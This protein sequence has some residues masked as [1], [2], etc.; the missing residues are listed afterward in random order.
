M[1][2]MSIFHRNALKVLVLLLM[3]SAASA[4]TAWHDRSIAEL[5]ELLIA[6]ELSAVTL[7]R[8]YLDR[9]EAFDTE[10]ASVIATSP[11][12][13]EQ[14]GAL[15]R[16]LAEGGTPGPLHGIPILLKDNIEAR[17]LPTTAGSL[18]LQ[19]NH[20]RRDA[21]LVASLR[22]AGAVI[23]GKTNLSE[24]ANFR[25]ERSSS[26]WSAVGGQ[27]RNP[28]DPTRT[29]C[30]SS[31]GSGVAV[32]AGFAPVAIGTE[33]NGSVV[34][35][36][37]ANGNAAI[38][39]TV[40]LVSRTHIVPISHTQD[41]AGPM[42]MNLADAVRVLAAMMGPDPADSA[43]AEQPDWDR[44]ELL[45]ALDQASLQGMR[46][47]VIRGLS[48]FHPRVTD[49]YEEAVTLLEASGA[50]VVDDL[51]LDWPDGFW[52]DTYSVLLHEFRHTLNSYLA[53]L[54][55]EQLSQLDLAALIEF[56]QTYAEVQMPWFGQEHFER[57][58]ATDGIESETYLEALARIQSATRAGG[59]DR[60][61]AEFEVDVLVSP[62]GGPAWKIDWIN[63]DHFG[64]GSATPA[65]VSGYPAITVPMGA[66]HGMPVGLSFFAGRY[67]E[68][69]LIRA[70]Q[71][72]ESAREP[73]PSPNLDSRPGP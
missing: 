26:G 37:T 10:L 61:L 12:A 38:K 59:I 45:D 40:G 7:T 25:G 55:D 35:P 44:E 8:H 24:W 34:C 36:A 11:D 70:A 72:F 30:G 32:A 22:A 31:S 52:E 21:P 13:L 71:A 5:H 67:S 64:G 54:P 41:T 16:H 43:T 56:N 58:E 46:V 4:Q 53:S 73:L 14:A 68:P 20:T 23:L 49:I 65:A 57:A 9:I 48:N 18:A 51:N 28:F 17:E 62:T 66:I 47:G 29:P 3:T 33:T 27:T 39:P 15:D 69:A 6:G 60:L 63:G 19:E 50:E 2:P 42:A 1:L